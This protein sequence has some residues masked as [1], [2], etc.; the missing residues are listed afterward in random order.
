M[1]NIPYLSHIFFIMLCAQS[2]SRDQLFVNL[3][4]IA[5]HT[6][7]SMR[8][9]RQ[10]YWSGL[11]CTPPRDLPN[12]GIEPM[13]ISL[14]HWQA[15]S[16]S[17]AWIIIKSSSCFHSFGQI[18][19]GFLVH[20]IIF[21][22]AIMRVELLLFSFSAVS[23]SLW[24]HRLQHTRLSSPSPSPEFTQTHV[25]WVRDAIQSSHPLS[26]PFPPTFNL[27]QHQN[28]FQYPFPRSKMQKPAFCIR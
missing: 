27:S 21:I 6:P 3:W 10:E 23:D 28:L 16:L 11:P 17:L 19:E 14:L 1:K 22:I 24:P 12:P 15:D 5:C 8:F 7:L 4:T 13:S 18:L 20:K 25:H 26:P 2:L 9:S